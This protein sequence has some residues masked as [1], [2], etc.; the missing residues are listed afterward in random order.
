VPDQD[1]AVVTHGYG[2]F[3]TDDRTPGGDYVT[4]AC[5][6]DGSLVM[7]YVA[8]HENLWKEMRTR[9]IAA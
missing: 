9:K 8:V 4:T 5:T 2:T 3:G 1:H 6:G 7:A